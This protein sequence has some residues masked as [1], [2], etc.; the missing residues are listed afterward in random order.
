MKHQLQWRGNHAQYGSR[1]GEVVPLRSGEWRP[2]ARGHTYSK[3][4]SRH[5]AVQVVEKALKFESLLMTR[6]SDVG[7]GLVVVHPSLVPQ[8]ELRT[9]SMY[10][11]C[12]RCLRTLP[13]QTVR[14]VFETFKHKRMQ[15]TRVHHFECPNGCA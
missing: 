8:S 15:R 12:G 7:M 3:E 9:I 14:V 13:P 2:I 5:A 4:S 11:T 1:K 6:M 10:W